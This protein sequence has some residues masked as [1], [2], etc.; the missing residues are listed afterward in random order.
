MRENAQDSA[1]S[2][3]IPAV[4]RLLIKNPR[5]LHKQFCGNPVFSWENEMK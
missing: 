5:H 1:R 4:Y 3:G 2:S